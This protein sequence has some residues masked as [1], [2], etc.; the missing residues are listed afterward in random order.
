MDLDETE[1]VSKSFFEESEI[2]LPIRDPMPSNNP[3]TTQLF[4]ISWLVNLTYH[5]M[6][7]STLDVRW[8]KKK[9]KKKRKI[10]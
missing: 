9:K 5:K 4:I 1:I 3:T 10:D 6:Y 8:K 2:E 7:K